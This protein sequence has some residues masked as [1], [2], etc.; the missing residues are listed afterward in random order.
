MARIRTLKPEFWTDEKVALLPALTRLVFLGLISQAD[1]AGR[2]VDNV[3]LLDGLL[4]PYTDDTCAEALDDL[5][6]T[7]RIIR[8]RSSSGQPLIQVANWEKHQKVDKPSRYVLPAQEDSES[9]RDSRESVARVSRPDL[10]P[11]TPERG[12]AIPEKR[13]D[14]TTGREEAKAEMQE[15]ANAHYESLPPEKRAAFKAE[16]RG[17]VSGD[18]AVSWKNGKTGLPIPWEERPPRLRLALDALTK[19]SAESLHW[20]LVFV[21]RQQDDPLELPTAE[22][23]Q[24]RPK[25]G[26]EAAAVLTEYPGGAYRPATTF[27]LEPVGP[28]PEPAPV[29]DLEAERIKRWEEEHRD[30]AERIRS[31]LASKL[32]SGAAEVPKGERAARAWADA[33]YRKRILERARAP[34]A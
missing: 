19:G 24:R 33:E 30:E 13:I 28:K 1:D 18:N 7:E 27:G 11:T 29:V 8:Y 12:T 17:V 15:A 10:R 14:Q 6:R 2:L 9:S 32:A 26:T 31:V 16:V 20:A 23:V 4:F 5:A 22:Q 25:P 21:H 34:A 3:K